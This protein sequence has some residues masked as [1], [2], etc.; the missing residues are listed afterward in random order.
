MVHRV[1]K[2]CIRIQTFLVR[3]NSSGKISLSADIS[4]DKLHPYSSPT[5]Q[6]SIA[7]AC[8]YVCC[9]SCSD[10]ILKDVTRGRESGG[11]PWVM[12]IVTPSRG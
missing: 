5:C 7:A 9:M 1:F 6:L 12:V 8:F 4:L 10:V 3:T 11:P 2:S